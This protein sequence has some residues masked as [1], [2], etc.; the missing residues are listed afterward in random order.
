M[1]TDKV[2]SIILAGGQG[3]RLH[4]L[5]D[6][7]SKPAVPIGGKFRLI[8][9]PISNCLH[10]GIRSIWVLTQFAS[11]SLHR[12][13]FQ[14]YRMDS[15]SSGFVSV[16]AASQ[17]PDSKGWYQG[18]ADAVRKNMV[19]F[20]KAGDTIL[21]LGG[22]HLYRMDYRKFIQFHNDNNADISL[23]VIPVERSK[24]RE[25]GIMK[26]DDDSRVT[27]FVEKPIDKSIVDEFE[28]PENL[29]AKNELFGSEEKTHVGSMGIYLFNKKVLFDLLNQYDYDDFGKQIIPAAISDYK[30]FAYPFNGYWEDIG[31][32]KAFFDAHID[33]TKKNPPFNFFDQEKP[34]FTRARFLPAA[35][36]S[37]ASI[38]SSIVCEGSIIDVATISDSIIGLRS[39]IR[40]GSKL[41][42]VI[43]MGADFYENEAEDSGLGI[44]K[45]CV[46]ENA[47]IDK[48]VRIGD[49]VY[50]VNKDRI[51]NG[52]KDGVF[53]REGIIIVPKSARI[54]SG[55]QL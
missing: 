45:N 32:I 39:V 34:I 41:T 52:E 31:T 25:L 29:R 12:H 16:L 33:M 23:A 40:S 53:I 46:I 47:I 2:T 49:D 10:N 9:I 15:F 42:R 5:T 26:L 51:Q 36:I 27:K 38:N 14:S 13:I 37:G 6:A 19:N 7:R 17:T 50:L 55:F 4:P 35:K 3:T 54:K 48:D 18:T 28:I 8:D 24:V 30:V 11:E 22:D 20:K 44:G 43:L 1:A 21:L